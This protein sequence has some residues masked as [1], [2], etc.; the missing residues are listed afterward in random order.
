MGFLTDLIEGAIESKLSGNNS[1]Q[2]QSQTEKYSSS[3]YGG[4]SG[5]QSGPP[6]PPQVPY[7]WVA[8]WDD[9][10]QRWFFLNEQTGQTSWEVPSSG[11]YSSGGYNSGVPQQGYY[12]GSGGGEY[13]SSGYGGGA[14]QGGYYEQPVQQEEKKDHTMLYTGVGVAAGV[15]GGALLMHE[16]E[17]IHDE[18]E[19]KKDDFEQGVEDLPE[20]AARWTGEAVGEVEQIPDRVE[21]G[22][23]AVGDDIEDAVDDVEDFP[24]NA[25]GWVGERVGEVEQFGDNMEDAYDDGVAEGRG[26]DW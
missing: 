2:P 21:G 19:E 7:P 1:S 6:Q 16:G 25:A 18:F 8:R 15:V 23:D 17:E 11:G 22:F 3:S 26:N 24:E 9:R 20:N 12:G 5:Y 4:G 10:D 14:P 13:S